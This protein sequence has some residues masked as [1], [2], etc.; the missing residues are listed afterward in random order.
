MCNPRNFAIA[1]LSIFL[2][3]I[4]M[5]GPA[6]AAKRIALLIGNSAYQH[7]GELE[8]PQNDAQLIA[9]ALRHAGF[10]V[11]IQ[12]DADLKTLKE[13]FR[14][15]AAK[16]Q[17]AGKD[18]VGF[19]Y[20]AGHGTQVKGV[21]Y[22]LP[23]DANIENE[24]QVES[25]AVSASG[26]LAQLEGAGNKMNLVIL[27]SC[28]NNPFKRGYRSQ[29]QGLAPMHAPASTLIGY[30]TQPG[31]VAYDGTNGYSPYAIALHR[32]IRQPG[33]TIEQS[34]KQAR[35][36][37]NE[38]TGG[39]QIPWEESS[40]FTDFY[41]FEKD[42]K[43]SLAP[44]AW[45]GKAF[46]QEATFW[47]DIRDSRDPGAFRSYLKKHPKGTFTLLA[48]ERI[49]DLKQLA[50]AKPVETTNTAAAGTYFFDDF[51]GNELGKDWDIMNP[52]PDSYIVEDGKLTVLLS[53]TQ[54]PTMDNIPNIFRLLKPIPKGDWTMTAKLEFVPQTMSEWMRIGVTKRD[55][56]GLMS[57]LQLSTHSYG[58]DTR[59]YVRGDKRTR[60]T[61]EF[62][63]ELLKLYVKDGRNIKARTNAFAGYVSTIYLR[64]KKRGRRY[65]SSIRFEAPA[66]LDQSKAVAKDWVE[67]PKLTSLR[68]PG[69]R[70]TLLFRTTRTDNHL[71]A[72]TESLVS[73]DWVKIEVPQ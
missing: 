8:N 60:K 5:V 15:H 46:E 50:D 71:P 52:D 40:L 7:S 37:V 56:N 35:S 49:D 19:F 25:E 54:K 21:N 1:A 13:A 28:R 72:K 45:D 41:F 36:E 29:V 62:S 12:T 16:L 38:V 20:Y 65:I 57:S 30:S 68:V 73:I 47:K 51:N 24:A 22:L 34:F 6:G 64:L 10:E 69:D 23:V 32:A 4:L 26:L 27:D 58:R 53:D 59:V 63:Q 14:E 42:Q 11:T 70:F 33:Q 3:L 66:S 17:A 67:L 9:S 55:G 31:N 44:A 48:N 39:K 43:A 61:S 2:T 18:S